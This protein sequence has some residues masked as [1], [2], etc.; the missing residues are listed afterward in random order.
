MVIQYR[1]VALDKLASPDELDQLPRLVSPRMWVAGTLLVFLVAGVVVWG[2]LGRIPVKVDAMGTFLTLSGMAPVETLYAGELQEVLVKVG[3]TVHAGQIVAM[4]GQTELEDQIDDDLEKLENLLRQYE[5]KKRFGEEN[6]RNQQQKRLLDKMNYQM[7]L[8][9]NHRYIGWLKEKVQNQKALWH[10]GLDTKEAYIQAQTDYENA[11]NKNQ[12]IE[13]NLQQ[14]TVDNIQGENQL[15]QDL[16]DMQ[17]SVHE[18]KLAAEQ[19]REKLR[20]QRNLRSQYTGRVITISAETGRMLTASTEI[21]RLERQNKQ[22]EEVIAKLYVAPNDGPKIHP[23]MDVSISPFSIE[24][25][26]Y[27]E[28]RGFVTRVSEYTVNN[29]A[30]RQVLQNDLLV[31]NLTANGA[32]Y[33]TTV[34]LLPDPSTVS[35]LKWTTRKGPPIQIRGGTLCSASVVVEQKRPLAFVVPFIRK[36]VLGFETQKWVRDDED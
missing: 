5:D 28:L 3:D 36:K 15:R 12:Q 9:I 34:C 29:E 7:E 18:Q 22:A 20:R 21:L 17:R 1:Q 8:E 33:E 26:E 23:G 30:M 31:Q 35:G 25:G 4:L 14:L 19:T 10:K 16:N 11:L 24:T 13:A 6:L 27:G 32:P 2:W